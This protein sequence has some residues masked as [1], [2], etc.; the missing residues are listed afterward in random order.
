MSSVRTERREEQGQCR[1]CR[2]PLTITAL[3]CDGQRAPMLMPTCDTCIAEEEALFAKPTGRES[4]GAAGPQGTVDWLASIGV[5]TRKHGNATF[6]TF[7]SSE[8]P[9]ALRVTRAF[10]EDV[11]A[12]Q[13]HDRVRGLYLAGP[14]G[15]GKS[16]LAVAVI[17]A[18]HEARPAL[19]VIYE[20]ADRL[21]TRVQDTYGSG[22]TDAFIEQR[23]RAGLYV[24]DDLGREKPTAD[25][26]RVLAT[27][28]DERE[29]APTVITSNQLPHELG[30]RHEESI[31]WGRIA[32][33]LG[34]EVYRYV[35]VAGRDRRFRA[36]GTA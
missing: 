17:H 6:E 32:S 25:A 1:V 15:A 35:L 26:L 2:T 21:V 20:P 23:K 30:A 12:S 36:E 18:L 24:L 28:L 22:T 10:V 4:E 9:A 31:E 5:N 16:H 11:L 3:Y 34:D 13:R 8:A 14:T 27:I 33:R 29:G 7:D 19:S